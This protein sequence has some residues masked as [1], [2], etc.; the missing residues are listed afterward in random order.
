MRFGL[1][2]RFSAAV[3]GVVGLAIISAATGLYSSR[4]TAGL[5]DQAVRKNLASV[6]AA[7]EL[8]IALLEQRG[9]VSSYI[10]AEGD[11]ARLHDL[12][13]KEARFHDWLETARISAHTDEEHDILRRLEIVY[14]QYCAARQRVLDLYEQGD[15][16]RAT[17]VLLGEVSDLYATA[18]NLCE[19][20]I[21]A[22]MRY[23]EDT[24]A[25]ARNQTRQTM[26]VA[27]TVALLTLG[28]G[29]G[30][31]GCSS[32]GCCYRCGGC[33]PTPGHLPAIRP[34]GGAWGMRCTKRA[35]ICSC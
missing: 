23:V 15:V 2:T 24:M 3:L 34:P 14:P 11:E 27:S 28:L 12:P 5:L 26:W 20:F 30:C 10:L 8:E 21:D 17:E 6:R 32:P 22:N 18:Y 33:S 13:A 31:C 19:D 1:A 35:S 16:A 9:A 4:T 7:E 29:E 25:L